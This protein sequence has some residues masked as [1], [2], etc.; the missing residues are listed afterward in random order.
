MLR[1]MVISVG[2]F[3]LLLMALPSDAKRDSLNPPSKPNILF[4]VVDDIAIDQLQTLY[5]GFEDIGDEIPE[6]PNIASISEAGVRFR[7]AWSMPACPTSRA[8]FFT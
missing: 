6:T 5:D 4:V 2:L 1:Y 7:N 3:G 8:V